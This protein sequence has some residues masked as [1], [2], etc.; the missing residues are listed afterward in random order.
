MFEFTEKKNRGG[1]GK[2]LVGYERLG[3]GNEDYIW[4]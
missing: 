2:G 4:R 3:V 1:R